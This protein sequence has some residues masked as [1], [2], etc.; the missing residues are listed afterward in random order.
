MRETSIEN[1][2]GFE[3]LSEDEKEYFRIMQSEAAFKMSHHYR[4]G[5]FET[6]LGILLWTIYIFFSIFSKCIDI[7]TFYSVFFL[8]IDLVYFIEELHSE[9]DRYGPLR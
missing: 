7:I 9:H 8:I 6:V 4:P 1:I 3:E 5:K 2:E